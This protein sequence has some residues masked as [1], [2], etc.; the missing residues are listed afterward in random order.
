MKKKLLFLLL[1]CVLFIIVVCV[2]FFILK[3]AVKEGQL[4]IITSPAANVLINNQTKGK[5]PYEISLPEG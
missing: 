4:K 2:R 1:I 5:S 3:S